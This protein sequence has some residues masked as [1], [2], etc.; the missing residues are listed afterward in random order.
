MDNQHNN[1]Q[2]FEISKIY[3]KDV[4]LEVPHAPKIFFENKEIRNEV[5][6]ATQV[7]TL[8]NNIF[9]IVLTITITAKIGDDITVY[10]VEVSQ[11]GLFI[12][13][14]FTKDHINYIVR[15]TCPTVLLPFI[16]EEI[17][18]LIGKSGF[19]PLWLQPINFEHFIK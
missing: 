17:A 12:I 2:C 1:H 8:D 19:P 14:G 9:E 7:V 3:L 13:R 11:A 15:T 5:K 10:L 4:S 16:R 6:L 18:N